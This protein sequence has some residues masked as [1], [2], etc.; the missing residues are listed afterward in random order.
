MSRKRKGNVLSSCLT[1]AGTNALVTMPLAE[2][3]QKVQDCENNLVRII[4]GA[5]SADKRKWM[6][7]RDGVRKFLRRNW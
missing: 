6:R 1:P 7:V 3:Q 5:K 2:K 4:M